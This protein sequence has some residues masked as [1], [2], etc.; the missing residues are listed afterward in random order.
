MERIPEPLRVPMFPSLL[1]PSPPLDNSDRD[2]QQE[3]LG[4]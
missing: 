2:L 1:M 3:T 4:D